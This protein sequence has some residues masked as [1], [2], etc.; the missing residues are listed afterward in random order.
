MAKD[1]KRADREMDKCDC[2]D[3]DNLKYYTGLYTGLPF[4]QPL[5]YYQEE[6]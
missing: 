5:F 3:D 4:Q 2:F 1:Y 6:P